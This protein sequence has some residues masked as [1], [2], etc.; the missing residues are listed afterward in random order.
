[1]K[2]FITNSYLVSSRFRQ[3]VFQYVLYSVLLCVCDS[4]LKSTKLCEGTACQRKLTLVTS[5]R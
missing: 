3:L 5:I 1:M 2:L 4:D